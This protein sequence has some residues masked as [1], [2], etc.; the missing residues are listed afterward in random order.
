MNKENNINEINEKSDFNSFEEGYL[1]DCTNI[2]NLVFDIDEGTEEFKFEINLR[3]I[4]SKAWGQESK[5]IV[6]DSSDVHIDDVILNQ[7]KPNEEKSYMIT[8]ENLNNYPVGEY[9]ILFYFCSGGRIYGD[10]IVAT[11]KKKEKINKI[12]EI[13]ECTDK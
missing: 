10:E 12:I 4:G 8:L 6:D 13:K 3:N 2:L 7:Q 5:L 11:I 9:K 1:F